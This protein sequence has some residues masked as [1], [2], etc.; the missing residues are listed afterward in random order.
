MNK[1]MSM[2]A[3]YYPY[4]SSSQI[5]GPPSDQYSISQYPNVQNIP[6]QMSMQFPPYPPSVP[7]NQL[8]SSHQPNIPY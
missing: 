4:G 2:G 7:Y 6:F 8:N 5:R 1:Q 3:G